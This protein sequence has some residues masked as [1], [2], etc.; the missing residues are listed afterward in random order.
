[1][2]APTLTTPRLLLREPTEADI[3]AIHE[4]HRHKAVSDGV[5][6]IPHPHTLDDARAWLERHTR[7]AEPDRLSHR[8][9][10]CLAPSGQP[11]GN[12]GI[13]MDLKHRR[14]VLGYLMHP[15]HWGRG[16]I[17]EAVAAVIQHAFTSHTPPLI[18]IEA[19]HYTDNPASARVLEKL[20]FEREG[21]LRSYIIKNGV[22]R[23]VVR[24]AMLN[25]RPAL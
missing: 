19:D 13:H 14:G 5:I 24:W 10:I 21:T 23:D 3:A 4:I 2:P 22:P 17:T 15:D 16:Y 8:W 12:C 9:M 7:P 11:I 25:P 6:S 1:M 18:R 20:G